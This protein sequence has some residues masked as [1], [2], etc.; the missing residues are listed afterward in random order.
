MP[1]LYG[2]IPTKIYWYGSG[3]DPLDETDNTGS[4]VNAAFNGYIFFGGKRIARRDS[5]NNVNYYFAAVV[6]P[7]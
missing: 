1:D 6:S 7:R 3:S 5:S 4:T 2:W